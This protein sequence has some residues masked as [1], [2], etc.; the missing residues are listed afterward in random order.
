MLCE[1]CVYASPM[2][3]VHSDT[4]KYCARLAGWIETVTVK[5]CKPFKEREDKELGE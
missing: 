4:A 5:D 3:H 1:K 2:K